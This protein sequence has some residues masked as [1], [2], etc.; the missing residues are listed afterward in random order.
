MLLFVLCNS[1]SLLRGPLAILFM[2]GDPFVRIW[3]LA[4]AVLTDVFDGYLARLSKTTSRFGAMID[5]LMDKFFVFFILSIFIMEKKLLPFQALAFVSRDLFLLLFALYLTATRGWKRQKFHAI[6]W[7]KV[8]TA[9]QFSVLIALTM[10][11]ILP[12][13]VYGLFSVLGF[14][15]FV[16]LVYRSKRASR[17]A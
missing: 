2:S 6:F 14:L 10:G 17:V 11:V 4:L 16:E 1:L 5:P 3:A 9:L 12:W 8:S 15:C 7:G 13:S